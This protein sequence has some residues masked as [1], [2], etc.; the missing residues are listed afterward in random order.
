MEC[1]KEFLSLKVNE[2]RKH[3]IYRKTLSVHSPHFRFP[4]VRF[5]RIKLDSED[6]LVSFMG[7]SFRHSI[8]GFTGPKN[9]PC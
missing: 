4:L 1:I 5:I 3:I 8:T 7:R 9:P 2:N 6:S